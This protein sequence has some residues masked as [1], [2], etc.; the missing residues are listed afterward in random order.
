MCVLR[1]PFF[2]VKMPRAELTDAP[3]PQ[4][5]GLKLSLI[6]RLR[7]LYPENAR[8]V[9]EPPVVSSVVLTER[10]HG[11]DYDVRSGGE[12]ECVLALQVPREECWTARKGT[13]YELDVVLRVEVECGFL[14]CVFPSDSG[15]ARRRD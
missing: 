12:R 5:T 4:V 10:F 9:V 1:F 7:I 8:P 2:G 11:I 3:R 6:R 13:L 15:M 14:Q